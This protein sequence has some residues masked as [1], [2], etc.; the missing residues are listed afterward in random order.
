MTT[1]GRAWILAAVYSWG[2]PPSS[3]VDGRVVL[4][5]DDM[6]DAD[7]AGTV[8][9]AE[10]AAGNLIVIELENGLFVLLAHLQHGGRPVMPTCI[11]PPTRI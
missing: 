5:R 6:E 1:Q 7:G 4:T 8:N 10:D 9:A 2:Q 11:F 3:P